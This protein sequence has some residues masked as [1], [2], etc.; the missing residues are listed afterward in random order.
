MILGGWAR[1]FL[2]VYVWKGVWLLVIIVFNVI[3]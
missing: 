1:Y 3:V 2:G